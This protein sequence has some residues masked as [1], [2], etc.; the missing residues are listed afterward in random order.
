MRYGAPQPDEQHD[1]GGRDLVAGRMGGAG[2]R[3]PVALAH[4][5]AQGAFRLTRHHLPRAPRRRPAHD[6]E[7][8]C[9][10]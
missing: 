1:R 9:G 8:G 10:R 5:S 3:E 4:G 6:V 7:C 2:L